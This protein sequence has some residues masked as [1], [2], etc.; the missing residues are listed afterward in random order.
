MTINDKNCSWS[1]FRQFASTSRF[2]DGYPDILPPQISIHTTHGWL[3]KEKLEELENLGS[4]LWED[5]GH[6]QVMHSFI[7]Q[8]EELAESAFDIT[9]LEV[10]H[11]LFAH[12]QASNRKA[13]KSKF[14]KDT[15]TCGICL[16]P[17]K[18]SVCHEME[19]CSHV[20]CVECLQAHYNN[21]ILLGN[22]NNV[23]CPEVNCGLENAS[24]LERRTAK[25]RLI[26]PSELLRIP[27]QRPAVQRF[28]DMR[29]KKLLDTD[30]STIWCPRKWCQGAAEGS[31]YPKPKEAL[32]DMHKVLEPKEPTVRTACAPPEPS[33][34]DDEVAKEKQILADRLRVC[35]DCTYASCKLCRTT[36]HGSYYDCRP[37]TE[38]LAGRAEIS[39]EEQASN[40]F[41]LA[42][43]TKCPT[44]TAPVQ[45]SEA[46]NHMRCGQC[47]AHFCYLC[48]ADL[49]PMDPYTHFSVEGSSCYNKLWVL[50]EG[51]NGQSVADFGG[52]RG[53][54]L[55][56]NGVDGVEAQ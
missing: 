43:A 24:A 26:A 30:R 28:V 23:R 2:P 51:D 34:E 19:H 8:I 46:C 32:E 50:R 3:S 7:T 49:S 47:L 42:N 18:G 25:V 36:W 22:V 44:C 10:S 1:I 27:L 14:E 31:S 33:E 39:K 52:V 20:F 6:A 12:L 53:V 35:E 17:K 29:R 9:S 11:D 55:Q 38:T 5:Y 41:I 13:K 37:R 21:A 4:S 48:G 16:D 45:K 56:E 54:A 15:Y 40:E